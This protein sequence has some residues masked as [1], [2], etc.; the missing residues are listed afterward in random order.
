MAKDRSEKLGGQGPAQPLS[1]QTADMEAEYDTTGAVVETTG[2][3]LRP[4]SADPI[5]GRGADT[6]PHTANRP[7]A[8]DRNIAGRS[9]A[10]TGAGS[11]SQTGMAEADLDPA[12]GGLGDTGEAGSVSPSRSRERTATYGTDTEPLAGGAARPKP[13]RK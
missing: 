11:H 2:R 8:P 9:G 4:R 7:P 13:K 6:G 10:D 3:G 5:A 12:T 1:E